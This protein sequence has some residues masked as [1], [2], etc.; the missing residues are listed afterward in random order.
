M[1]N[2]QVY[3]EMESYILNKDY[4]ILL[5]QGFKKTG[6]VDFKVKLSQW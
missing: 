6:R 4:K 2:N 1:P 5:N 3:C